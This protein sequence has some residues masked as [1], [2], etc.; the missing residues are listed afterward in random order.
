MKKFYSILALFCAATFGLLA[1]HNTM[2]F[3]GPATLAVDGFGQVASNESDTVLFAMNTQKLTAD[4][5]IPA[6]SYNMGGN[7]RVIPSF[8]IHGAAFTMDMTTMNATFADQTFSETTTD[9]TGVEKAVTGASLT[10]SYTHADRK[11]CITATYAYGGMPLN[12]TYA[13][14]GIYVAPTSL[15][16]IEEHATSTATYDLLGNRWNGQKGIVIKNGRLTIICP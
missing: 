5:T 16:S 15:T 11:L 14:E 2:T 1:Q 7:Q 3:A 6:I 12:I 10:G 8:T 4:I 13:F 9:A